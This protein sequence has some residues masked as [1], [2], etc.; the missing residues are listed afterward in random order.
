LLPI[1]GGM[2]SVSAKTPAGG[3]MNYRI[4]RGSTARAAFTVVLGAPKKW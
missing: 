1:T 4:L 2:W 3:E